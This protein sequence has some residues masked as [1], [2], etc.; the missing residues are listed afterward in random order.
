MH[1]EITVILDTGSTKG[2]GH[3]IA[4]AFVEV[5]A[6]VVVLGRDLTQVKQSQEAL[7]AYVGVSG[8][9]GSDSGCQQVLG[10][11]GKLDS[12]DVL[13][14]SCAISVCPL[15]PLISAP[16]LPSFVHQNPWVT[17]TREKMRDRIAAGFSATCGVCM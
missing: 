2:I 16:L 3:A 11:L 14:L 9:L 13:I 12:V 4:H 10:Q 1:S 7:G 6:S 5:G 15:S 17:Q 8:E